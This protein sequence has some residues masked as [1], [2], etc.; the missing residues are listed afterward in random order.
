ME[1]LT[2]CLKEKCRVQNE[3]DVKHIKK[4]LRVASCQIFDR[5]FHSY[6]IN[7]H[8]KSEANFMQEVQ[9]FTCTKCF[10]ITDVM[11]EIV[12]TKVSALFDVMNNKLCNK[13]NEMHK[14]CN[15]VSVDRE[16]ASSAINELLPQNI[17]T[18]SPDISEIDKQHQQQQQQHNWRLQRPPSH[19]GQ[20]CT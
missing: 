11:A 18:L 16:I 3:K 1:N 4:H 5:S 8:T 2:C 15:T 13:L 19:L 12:A 10:R 7:Y 9:L 6:C 20:S 17:P 14:C